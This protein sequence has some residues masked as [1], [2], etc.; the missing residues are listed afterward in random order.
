MIQLA[1]AQPYRFASLVNIDGIPSKRPIPDVAEHDRT[2]MLVGEL[3]GWLDHRQRTSG[4][5]RKPGT[6]DE[7]AKRQN[8]DGSWSNE[9]ARWLEGDASLVTA[10]VLMALAHCEVK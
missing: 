8:S 3:N 10:Y 7:L 9:N 5:Q 2:K 1:D 6:I 4:S